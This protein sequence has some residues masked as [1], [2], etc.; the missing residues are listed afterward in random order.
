MLYE[1]ITLAGKMVL[2]IVGPPVE[3][4]IQVLG[5]F[6]GMRNVALGYAKALRHDGR[7][8]VAVAFG[9]L[10]FKAIGSMKTGKPFSWICNT[11]F[12]RPVG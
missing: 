8:Q 6:Q 5:L 3:V 4:R 7:Y 1:V 10:L 11:I 9:M 12:W 2:M